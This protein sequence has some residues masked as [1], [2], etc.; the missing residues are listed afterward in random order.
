VGKKKDYNYISTMSVASGK[1][2]NAPVH[3][4]DED[5]YNVDQ[6]FDNNY[7]QS[8][9]QA[10]MDAL[11][12]REHGVNINIFRVGNLVFDSSTGSFQRNINQNAFYLLFR[13]IYQIKR[14]PILKDKIWD[15]SYVDQTAD[16]IV[17]IFD[18][19]NLQNKTFHIQNSN[20]TSPND[21]F[22]TLLGDSAAMDIDSYVNFLVQMKK[23]G[24]YVDEI[25]QLIIHGNVHKLGRET[26]FYLDNTFSEFILKMLEFTWKDVSSDMLYKMINY[27][28]EIGFM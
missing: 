13:A 5:S 19:T 20:M 28:K 17:R 26:V 16:A 3:Y 2:E 15:F 21:C 1:I 22:T 4:F 9:L 25:D 12:Y 10:E 27:C 8:K 6:L 14:F 18:K 24:K 7:I 23:D 11:K